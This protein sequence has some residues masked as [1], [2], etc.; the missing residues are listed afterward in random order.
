MDLDFDQDDYSGAKKSSDKNDKSRI[1]SS[2]TGK[3]GWADKLKK[4]V[5][6]K[7]DQPK[8]AAENDREAD[9]E[10]LRLLEE[11]KSMNEKINPTYK[12]IPKFFFKKPKEREDSL[13]HRVR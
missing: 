12:S 4:Y 7:Q 1:S 3:F 5:A 9:I 2:L 6:S 10:F 8:T 13:Y 11:E